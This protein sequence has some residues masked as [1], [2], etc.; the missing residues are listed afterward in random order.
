MEK[1]RIIGN[2]DLGILNAEINKLAEEG[3]RPIMMQ[4]V[5]YEPTEGD[6]RAKT[7]GGALQILVMMAR[8]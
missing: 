4:A 7:L 1:Y 6:I 8:G 3:F 2:R 5:V